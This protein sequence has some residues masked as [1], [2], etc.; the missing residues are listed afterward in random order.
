MA[1]ITETLSRLLSETEE[2]IKTLAPQAWQ[3]LVVAARVD[4]IKGCCIVALC[5]LYLV[6]YLIITPIVLSRAPPWD[7]I[8]AVPAYSEFATM[9]WGLCTIGAVI[10]FIS[11]LTVISDSRT[12]MGLIAPQAQVVRDLMG[13]FRD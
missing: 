2:A 3:S 8:R 4:S 10:S 1:N 5:L 7:Y 9:F 6:A 11:L 13:K 12:W